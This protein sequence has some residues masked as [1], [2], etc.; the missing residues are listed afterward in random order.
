M[1]STSRL[2]SPRAKRI[3]LWSAAGVGG[4]PELA[5]H[6]VG[7]LTDPDLPSGTDRI[8]AALRAVDPER[9][10]AQVVNLQGDLPTLEPEAV[11]QVLP[12][13]K[14]SQIPHQRV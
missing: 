7:V 12:L 9:R 14:W 8:F 11:R 6:V 10:F 1:P 2:W 13:K 3:A 4:A 5:G